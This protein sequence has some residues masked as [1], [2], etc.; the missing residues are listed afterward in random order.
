VAVVVSSS[1]GKQLYEL[2]MVSLTPNEF[3]SYSVEFV[4]PVNGI[5]GVLVFGPQAGVDVLLDGIVLTKVIATTVV[6]TN[7]TLVNEGFESSSNG[8][9]AI[10]GGVAT[11]VNTAFAEGKYSLRISQRTSI[12][13]G[14]AV[15]LGAQLLAGKNYNLNAKLRVGGAATG[16]ANVQIWLAFNDSRGAQ[17][18]SLGAGTIPLNTWAGLNATF[19]AY[20]VGTMTNAQI[21]FVGPAAGQ[22]VYLDA[23]KLNSVN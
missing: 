21:M 4:A 8:W 23:V 16:S 7:T 2:P 22:D 6:T 5:N 1:T 3:T 11:I 12:N 14:A 15:Q 13:S 10:F 19:N 17:K 18:I 9:S 20:A